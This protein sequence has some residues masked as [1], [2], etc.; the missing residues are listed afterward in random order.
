MNKK[1]IVNVIMNIAIVILALLFLF[2]FAFM[3]DS[4]KWAKEKAEEKAEWSE[5]SGLEYDLEHKA[6]DRILNTYY[7]YGEPGFDP[8]SGYENTCNI[9]EYCH[10]TFM[11]KVYEAEG[12]ADRI[13]LC[14]EKR[15]AVKERLGAYSYI[16]D[17]VDGII[18]D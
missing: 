6:Y 14:E 11:S 3:I 12:D 1:K 15:K 18:F 2:Q 9:G 4:F 8:V 13:R 17:E 16:A 7:V 10:L 5:I